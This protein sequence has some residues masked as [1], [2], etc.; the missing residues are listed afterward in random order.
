MQRNTE[1]TKEQELKERQRLIPFHMHINLEL[2]E[3][4]YLV[5]AMLIEI[6]YMCSRDYETKKR[7]ISKQFHYQLKFSERQPVVGPPENMREH[8]VAASRAMRSGDWRSCVAFL[9]NEK[10]NA[11]V[12]DLMAL[13]T[14]VTAML[15]E[16]VREE[17]L[18]SYLFKY[19]SVY[20]SMS[21]ANLA[22][23]FDLANS[24]V[25][26]I[27]S[28]MIINEE[29]MASLDEPTQTV[30]MH[31]TEPTKLQTL[32]LQLSEKI[33]TLM[34]QTERMIQIKGG[35]MGSF[36]QRNSKFLTK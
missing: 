1:K 26:S 27:I 15:V 6:P 36:F 10:M 22:E 12:W 35:E 20:E 14:N 9:I 25:Y 13:S 3:C 2:I 8:V 17:T 7:L 28:K 33:T 30:I 34:D 32:A 5:S 11:K 29:L 31:R 21:I 23:M 19:S 18:R 16:K 24:H 4:I